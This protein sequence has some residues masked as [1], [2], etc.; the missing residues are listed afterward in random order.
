MAPGRNGLEGAPDQPLHAQ[1]EA[2]VLPDQGLQ[3]FPVPTQEDE[4]V[5]GIWLMTELLFNHPREAVDPSSQ[6]LVI[7]GHIDPLHP[8]E[9]QHRLL[10]HFKAVA[11]TAWAW[12]A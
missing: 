5:A 1:P 12:C 2:A 4:A 10:R 8:R 3:L 11:R 9:T 6:I 7:P